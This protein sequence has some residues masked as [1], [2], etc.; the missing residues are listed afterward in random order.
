MEKEDSGLIQ[1]IIE[2][3]A[4]AAA[5]MNPADIVSKTE[6]RDICARNECGLLGTNWGC[7]PGCGDMEQ[8]LAG[9]TAYRSGVV[10][11]HV[12]VLDGA[13]DWEGMMMEK[14]AF[15][16]LARKVKELAGHKALV[17]GAGGCDGCGTCAYPR[18]C[19][20]PEQKLVSVEA[21]GI[22]VAALCAACGLRYANGEGTVTYTGLALW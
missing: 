17:L 12:G 10:F 5:P 22:D 4:Y 8:L 9:L 13:F 3:G 2:A 18:A 19:V 6:L 21:Y 15:S 20:F 14:A 11:Q 1:S 7:P 16:A